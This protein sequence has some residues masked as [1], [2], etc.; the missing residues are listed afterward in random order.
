MNKKIIGA[1]AIAMCAMGGSS[2]ALAQAT[3]SA[4]GRQ[5]SLVASVNAQHD[6]NSSRTN[7]SQ[8]AARGL[9]LSDE[10]LIPNLSVNIGL[11]I[12]PHSFSLGGSLGYEFHRRNKQR[13]RENIQLNSSFA[14]NLP[15]CDPS[16]SGAFS[17]RLSDLADIAAVPDATPSVL[18]NVETVKSI[19][20]TV[21]CG[22]DVGIRPTIGIDY[23]EGRN[24]QALRKVR[25]KNV[26]TYILG[27]AYTHPLVGDVLLSAQQRDT[28][29]PNQI[30]IPDGIKNGN[31]MRSYGASFSRSIGSRLQG[32]VAV[33]YTDLNPRQAGVKSFHGLNWSASLSAQATSRM[34]VQASFSRGISSSL[35]VQSNYNVSTDYAL[36][37]S[38]ALTPLTSLSAG[39]TA[40]R[41]RF[42]GT[43]A[44]ILPGSPAPEQLIWDQRNTFFAS[45]SYQF[46]P[47]LRF[48]LDGAHERRNANSTFFDYHNNRVGLGVEFAL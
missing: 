8:A 46:S 29:Y 12:G 1:S 21:A 23:Q 11:P 43:Q 22:R 15:I 16:F 42:Q 34:A 20:A 40:Q 25:D 33:S 41:R 39:V 48:R 31:R 18:K 38:Y 13:D 47:K 10:K 26:T 27:V 45:V 17:R 2:A 6:S 37:V 28:R 44:I 9:N 24:N 19:G 7:A 35:A 32:S 14:M 4:P 5:I 3:G 30:L 36:D